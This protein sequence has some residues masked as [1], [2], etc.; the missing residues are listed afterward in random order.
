MPG[1]PARARARIP[2]FFIVG[3]QKSGTTAL[4]EMLRRHPQIYMPQTKEPRYFASDLR[5]NPRSRPALDTFAG[6][7]SL[8][9]EA[10]PDQR[11]GEASPV[12]LLSH[13]AAAN[14]A[15]VRPDARLI[16]ILREPASFLRSYHLQ[17]VQSRVET[18]RD[19]RR[20]MALEAQRREGRSMPA[21]A[22]WAR[23][24]LYSEHVRYVE[25]LRRLDAVFPRR[26]LLVLIY[27]DYRADNEA[28]VRRV[29]R[30][31]DVDETARIE[32]VDANPTVRVRR[33]RLHALLH[34]LSVGRGPGARSLKRS[35]RRLTPSGPRSRALAMARQHVVYSE[36]PP[37]DHDL[38]LELRRR[39]EP[40]VLALSEY[41]GRDLTSLW[42]YDRLD[43]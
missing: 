36:P 7:L 10:R 21:N 22:A 38:M 11:V 5:K 19:L 35:L 23:E 15:E 3:H 26:Q 17:C 14:I 25:Q 20:A 33:P 31:L 32:P 30:F 1:G 43:R 41:L 27:D 42:G 12:Y 37:A 39:F 6:Y 34:A 29:L 24:L 13:T 16:A 40:E 2:E 28:T 9:N 4:Y 8:F 18:E